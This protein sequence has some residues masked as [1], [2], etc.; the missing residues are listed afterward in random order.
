MSTTATRPDQW[1]MLAQKG[2]DCAWSLHA[3]RGEAEGEADIYR[4]QG[5]VIKAI[6]CGEEMAEFPIFVLDGHTDERAKNFAEVYRSG[7]DALEDDDT[8]GYLAGYEITL[9]N[10]RDL[11][12][13]ADRAVEWLEVRA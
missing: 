1:F 6:L 9:G 13:W 2:N 10:L 5:Y 11:K 3:T 4:R 12:R 7:K 8:V